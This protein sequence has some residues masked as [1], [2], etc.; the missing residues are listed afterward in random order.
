MAFTPYW[1]YKP[2]DAVHL[3]SPGVYTSEKILNLSTIKKIHW[4]CDCIDGC[5]LNGGRQPILYSFVL[6]K[7]PGLKV[8]F[9][10]ETIH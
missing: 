9:E 3:D 10:P 4:K 2:T 5:V 1:D 7:P 6:R 8:L